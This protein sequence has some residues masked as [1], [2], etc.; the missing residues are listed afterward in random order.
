MARKRRKVGQD[1]LSSR[2]RAGSSW[3][4]EHPE[5]QRLLSDTPITG[6]R[7]IMWGSNSTF[8][9]TLCG[10]GQSEGDSTT[11]DG[12]SHAIYKPRRG[13]APLYDFPR[14]TLYRR[15]MAT[16]LVSEALGWS[17]VPP[18]VVR[19]GP[20]GIGTVQLFIEH[21]PDQYYS[22][23]VRR[24]RDATEQIALLDVL[25]NNADRKSEHC[26]QSLDGRTWAIDHG[27]TFH[28]EPKLR[29]VIWDFANEPIGP[30]L[31]ADLQRACD[32]LDGRG[33]LA[34]A[35]RPLIAQEEVAMVAHRG[36]Q[37]I[38]SAVHPDPG[39]HRRAHP[40]GW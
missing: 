7:P 21:D 36:Q 40:W 18:T 34:Q 12:Q 6:C 25:L 20:Y 15:E 24:D 10:E 37:L 13:E 22:S 38:R 32:S 5:I 26:L 33:P 11:Q 1:G 16:Y 3:S 19:E 4:P 39:S 35:L 23:P 14:G 17:L 29:T 28:V 8:L 30:E 2:Q 27:L 9:V 31:L